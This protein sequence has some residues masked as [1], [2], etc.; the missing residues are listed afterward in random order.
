VTP[1]PAHQHQILGGGKFR[2]KR[3]LCW[4]AGSRSTT[5]TLL[6][7]AAADVL[8]LNLLADPELDVS[9][10]IAALHAPLTR[11]P[12]RRSPDQQPD[13]KP[14]RDIAGAD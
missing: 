1:Q 3:T 8:L 11:K 10:A 5:G 12:R 2:A 6:L 13:C 4:S 9:P 7:A 14:V